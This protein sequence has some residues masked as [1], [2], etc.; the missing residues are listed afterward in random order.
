MDRAILPSAQWCSWI[1][2]SCSSYKKLQNCAIYNK[3][4]SKDKQLKGKKICK[5]DF[6]S[7]LSSA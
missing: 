7:D 2:K 4:I 6:W 3:D 1:S 5:T